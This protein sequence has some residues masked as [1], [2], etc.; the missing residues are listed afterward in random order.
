MPSHCMTIRQFCSQGLFACSRRP[1]FT[2]DGITSPKFQVRRVFSK[3]Q[4]LGD[5]LLGL[6]A[7][8]QNAFSRKHTK[9]RWNSLLGLTILNTQQCLGWDRSTPHPFL[10]CFMPTLRTKHPLVY[11]G[12]P[13]ACKV[14]ARCC[15]LSPHTA[16]QQSP[17]NTFPLS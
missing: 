5:E 2:Q 9:H 6:C 10:L 12:Q 16:V 17:C 14:Q 7:R 4:L 15:L 3:P 13:Q 8:L 11:F 1:G